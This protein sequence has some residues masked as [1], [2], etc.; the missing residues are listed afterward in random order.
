MLPSQSETA[1]E[2]ILRKVTFWRKTECI[3]L[4][5]YLRKHCPENYERILRYAD[6]LIEKDSVGAE[7]EQDFIHALCVLEDR[8][9]I[10]LNHRQSELVHL[11][12]CIQISS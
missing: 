12:A 8:V 6:V 3:A 7:Q 2:T 10:V 1:P 9:K 4:V 5:H 11:H